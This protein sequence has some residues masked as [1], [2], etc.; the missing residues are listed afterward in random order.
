MQHEGNT[1]NIQLKD[2]ISCIESIIADFATDAFR[3]KT[4]GI[5]PAVGFISGIKDPHSL[6][7]LRGHIEV[8]L[9]ANDILCGCNTK[10]EKMQRDADVLPTPDDLPEWVQYVRVVHEG[11]DLVVIAL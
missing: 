10:P 8:Y 5:R 6:D 3:I 1:I 2:Y 4:T 11:T 7:L 9:E